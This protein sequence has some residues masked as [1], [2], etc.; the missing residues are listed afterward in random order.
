MIVKARTVPTP[1]RVSGARSCSLHPFVGECQN[2]PPV[3]HASPTNRRDGRLDLL[4]ICFSL[5]ALS[6]QI[7]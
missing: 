5:S 1:G 6:C 2:Q 7:F 3:P 4:V